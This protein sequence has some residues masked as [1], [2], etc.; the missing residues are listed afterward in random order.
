MVRNLDQEM[1]SLAAQTHSH[2]S[3]AP[4]KNTEIN[5]ILLPLESETIK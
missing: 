5:E 4:D 1:F 3:A 2:S